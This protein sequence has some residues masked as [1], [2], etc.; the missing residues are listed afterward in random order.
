M[1]AR[2]AIEDFL[3]GRMDILEFKRLYDGGE[4]I[5]D[6]LEGIVDS[7][8]K[9]GQE[10]KN[11]TTKWLLDPDRYPGFEYGADPYRSVR[12]LLNYEFRMITHNVRTAS[13]ASEFFEDVKALY[14]EI[15]PEIECTER[16][17]EA[18]CFA[19]DAIPE[20][21]SGGTAETFIQEHIIP[22]FP[23]TMKK[24]ERIKGIKAMIKEYFR[25]EKGRP[26]WIEGADWPMG[27]DGKPAVYLGS[28]KTLDG[29]GMCYVFRDESEK[30]DRAII[31]VEQMH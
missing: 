12:H 29:E 22:Q 7:F 20:Y 24:S 28:I 21:L 16:Y 18:F 19:L 17:H 14:Q 26:C 4:E 8:R 6:F 2:K 3:A 23:E 13:G 31:G 15:C 9:S 10:P 1:D 11:D 27:A 30:G 25:A 5:N